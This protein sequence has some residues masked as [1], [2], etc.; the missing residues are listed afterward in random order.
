MGSLEGKVA[1]IT[2]GTGALGTVVCREFLAAGARLVVTYVLDE[3]IARFE[4]SV[5]GGDYE[6]VKV[7]LTD[8][9]EVSKAVDR[10]AASHGR[11]DVLLNLAGGFW[12]GVT[13]A[14][15]PDVELEKLFAMNVR[16]AF[17]CA[18]AVVP[19]MQR[20]RFGRIVSVAARAALLGGGYVGAYAISKAGVVALTR[21]LADEVRDHGI[22]VNAIAPSTIDTPANR[23]AMPDADPSKWVKP[24]Q[25]AATLV[26]LASDAAGATSGT[27]IPIYAS[28]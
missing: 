1:L 14:E 5:T 17:N 28:A 24:E 20:R 18:R 23:A 7:D 9:A 25:I 12:G 16:T 3:E 26:F 15:T 13:V 19:H 21:A 6:L 22:T 11:V 2:G 10:I 27:V 8:A 4:A